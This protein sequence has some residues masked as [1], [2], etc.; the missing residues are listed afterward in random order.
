[1]KRLI[2]FALLIHLCVLAEKF[3]PWNSASL[4][5]N[6]VFTVQLGVLVIF[7]PCGDSEGTNLIYTD[8]EDVFNDCIPKANVSSD[9]LY[10]RIGTCVDN[11]WGRL[12]LNLIFA[13]TLYFLSDFE[14]ECEAGLKAKVIVTDNGPSPG[15]ETTVSAVDNSRHH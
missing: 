15:E 8:S 14:S 1:M 10:I 6:N 4:R 5:E 2:Q 11:S 13:D 9:V 12:S 7:E 3:I